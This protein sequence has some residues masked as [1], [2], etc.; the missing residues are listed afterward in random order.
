MVAEINWWIKGYS[1]VSMVDRPPF[2]MS[3]PSIWEC[4]S[5]KNTHPENF[6]FSGLPQPEKCL[7]MCFSERNVTEDSILSR[8]NQPFSLK[9]GEKLG[10]YVGYI[11]WNLKIFTNIL[12]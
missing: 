5:L 2:Q 7:K 8:S 6:S 1:S 3:N 12:V 10:I 11:H 4:F 9:L